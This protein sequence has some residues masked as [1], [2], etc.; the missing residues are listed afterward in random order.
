MDIKKVSIPARSVS[1]R[2]LEGDK[3]EVCVCV[4]GIIIV[5][6]LAL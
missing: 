4:G 5:T 1:Y 6:V 2:R 3:G